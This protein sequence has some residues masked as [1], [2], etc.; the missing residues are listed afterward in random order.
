MITEEKT[1]TLIKRNLAFWNREEL[2]RPLIS[3]RIESDFPMQDF[4]GGR[5]LQNRDRLLPED[6]HPEDFMGDY[7]KMM[8]DW[9]QVE[10]DTFLGLDPFMAIPWMEGILGCRISTSF[11]SSWAHPPEMSPEEWLQTPIDVK[12]NPWFLKAVEFLE[13]LDQL[14]GGRFPVSH[15]LFRGPADLLNSVVGHEEAVI[16]LIQNPDLCGA[17]LEKCTRIFI[18]VVQEYNRHLPLFHGGGVI[19]MF[20]VWSPEQGCR[21]Q[22]DGTSLYSPNIY[23]K[24]IHPCDTLISSH[25]RYNLF[26]LHPASFFILDDLLSIPTLNC[27]EISTDSAAQIAEIMPVF[28]K[29]LASNKCLLIEVKSGFEPLEPIFDHLPCKGLMVQIKKDTV[30]E[31]AGILEKLR[32]RFPDF[33]ME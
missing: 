32:Q 7:A 33:D 6:I 5:K 28:Q 30:E 19:G 9:E 24:F 4:A 26:H 12:S 3:F 14:A 29:I 23:R 22:E 20:N 25:W 10:Q 16:G 1:A 27:I 18:K 15:P 13:A 8:A 11:N 31:A 17:I 21:F 2:S